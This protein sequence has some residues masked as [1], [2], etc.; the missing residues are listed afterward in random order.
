MIAF[1]EFLWVL[2]RWDISHAV[3]GLIAS[4]ACVSDTP[5]SSVIPALHPC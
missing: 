5:F 4:I 2:E 1:F 3:L